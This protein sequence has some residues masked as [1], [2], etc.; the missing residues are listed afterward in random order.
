MLRAQIVCAVFAAALLTQDAEA[1]T[2]SLTESQA[3]ERLSAAS[4]RVQAVRA[5]VEVARADA[6]AAGRWPNPRVTFTREAVAGVTENMF[7][8]SQAVPLAGRRRFEMRAASARVEA[9][10]NRA[11]D[12]VRRFRADLRL[13]FTDLWAA[14]ARELELIRSRDRLRQLA[15]VLA[16]RESEGESAG[17]D[18]LRAEREV[19][20]VEADR[21]A[22]AAE[23]ARAQGV[24]AS[25]FAAPATSDV[26]E[27]VR[28][29]PS[30][31]PVPAVDELMTRAERTRGDFIALQRELDA[32]SFMEEAANR[33]RVPE[34]ELVAGTKSSNAGTGDSGSI[35][36]VHVN[37]PL[38]DR[39]APERAA[40]RARAAQL[41]AE[42][43]ALRLSVWTQIAA[44]RTALIERRAV[45]GEYRAAS[46]RAAEQIGR[47]AEVSYDAGEGNILELL[48][49]Y[50]TTSAARVRQA[51]LEAAVREAEIELE[52]VSG[53]E[54]P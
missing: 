41:R 6:L 28:P 26:I 24:L 17:F 16:R 2:L 4:P 11:D 53:W 46:T 34:P 1:Q 47:I 13:A 50:R 49:A 5:T 27:A 40:A 35:L 7:M 10:G 18:R 12:T 33:R 51:Q 48:D 30:T 39:G 25:F 19:I 9:A 44:W 32:S 31:S 45:A 43:E 38:F 21:A 52:F 37:V 54:M 8:V 29:E 23:R 14:Q 42:A 20:D 3:V 22:A 36:S 15:G